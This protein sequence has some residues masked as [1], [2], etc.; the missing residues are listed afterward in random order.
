MVSSKS[1]SGSGNAHKTG[2]TRTELVWPEVKANIISSF[3]VYNIV[4]NGHDFPY[5]ST[6]FALY[7][8]KVEILK[9]TVSSPELCIYMKIIELAEENRTV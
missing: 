1:V 5:K 4:T 3:S 9:K 8:K 7:A 2:E 6:I